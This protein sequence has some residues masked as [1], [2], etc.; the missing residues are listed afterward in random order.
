MEFLFI[1]HVVHLVEMCIWLKCAFGY[2]IHLFCIC[3]FNKKNSFSCDEEHG[4]T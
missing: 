1:T 2:Q 3:L 4:C